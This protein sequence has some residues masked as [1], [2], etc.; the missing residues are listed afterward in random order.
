[1]SVSKTP[2]VAAKYPPSRRSEHVDIYKSEKHGEVRVL[3]PYNWLEQNNEETEA[4][5]AKQA[6]YT[7]E[8]L[9]QYPHRDEI[10]KQLKDNFNYEKVRQHIRL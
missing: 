2:W 3:D 1:M 10:E 8:F 5:T 6:D 9:K 7:Q 4:W